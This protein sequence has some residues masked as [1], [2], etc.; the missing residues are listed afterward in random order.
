[1]FQTIFIAFC[2][3]VIP[4]YQTPAGGTYLPAAAYVSYSSKC[5]MQ[6]MHDIDRNIWF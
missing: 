1:M 2:E 4:Y 6:S 3:N 5:Y